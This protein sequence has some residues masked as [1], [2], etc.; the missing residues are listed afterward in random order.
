MNPKAKKSLITGAIGI[1][2]A[3]ATI[4]LSQFR[5]VDLIRLKA[6]DVHF[7]LR[8][9]EP[10]KDLVILG[11]DNET[12]ADPHFLDPMMFWQQHY[13]DAISAA[14]EGGGKVFVLDEAF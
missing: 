10:V 8:G 1:A 7:V 11:I 2:S 14:A 9:A 12:E 13:A 3:L 4:G 6:Q 5:I